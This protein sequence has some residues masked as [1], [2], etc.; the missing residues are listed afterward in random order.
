MTLFARL[1]VV[2]VR[3]DIRGSSRPEE[4]EGCK[5][6]RRA[7]LLRLLVLTRPGLSGD[8]DSAGVEGAAR[9]PF[10][11]SEAIIPVMRLGPTDFLGGREAGSGIGG[12]AEVE[13]RVLCLLVLSERFGCETLV[14]ICCVVE[15]VGCPE[16]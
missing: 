11:L 8:V 6:V 9:L 1:C 2:A 13:G 14:G 16:A 12:C 10:L 4:L 3:V 15:V 5:V 7:A